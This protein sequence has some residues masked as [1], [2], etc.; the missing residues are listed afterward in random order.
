M[1]TELTHNKFQ[2]YRNHC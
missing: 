2:P 1:S